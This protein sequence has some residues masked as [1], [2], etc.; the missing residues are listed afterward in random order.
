MGRGLSSIKITAQVL[1]NV[2]NTL[3]SGSTASSSMAGNISQTLT[4]GIG[5]S[6]ADRA[7]SYESQ[8]LLSGESLVIDV[9][10]FGGIDIGAGDGN[11]ALGQDLTLSNIVSFLV[12]N[13]NAV[14]TAGQLEIEPDATNGWVP[15][16]TH[17][18]ALSGALFG[19]GVLMKHQPADDGFPVV[20]ASSHRVKITA[21]G[22]DITFS[23]YI[24]GRSDTETSSSS[25]SSSS[26]SSS[27]CISTSSSPSSFSSPSSAS[28]LSESCLSTSSES[29]SSQSSVSSTP[30]T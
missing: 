14:D 1:A 27:S 23:V 7:W 30:P 9:F 28:C 6:Q 11:D 17:T 25:L 26:S 4:T 12:Q 10:D 24:L 16:G 8:K 22:G 3:V 15:I 29:C 2:T 20:D 19:K 21:N 13:E 18:A 5:D